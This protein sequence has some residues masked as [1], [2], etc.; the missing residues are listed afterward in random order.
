M[1]RPLNEVKP[2]SVG[3]VRGWVTKYEY[4]VF[5]FSFFLLRFQGDISSIY[6]LFVPHFTMAV[7]MCTYCTVKPVGACILGN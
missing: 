7:F 1:C 5:F 4:P 6:Q 2:C 3:L